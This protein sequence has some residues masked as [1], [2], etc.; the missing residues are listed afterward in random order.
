MT[1]CASA[2]LL[3][4]GHL[5]SFCG[6]TR[7]LHGNWNSVA[8]PRLPPL[9]KRLGDSQM[10][11]CIEVFPRR[12]NNQRTQPTRRVCVIMGHNGSFARHFSCPP[13]GSTKDRERGRST[14]R[15]QIGSARRPMRCDVFFNCLTIRDAMLRRLYTRRGTPGPGPAALRIAWF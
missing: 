7:S 10:N 11:P 4:V 14:S 9:Q 13:P 15:C 2:R 8:P 5:I 6:Q 12:R 3:S 1:S